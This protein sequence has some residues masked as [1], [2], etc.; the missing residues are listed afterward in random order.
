V[1]PAPES[2]QALSLVTQSLHLW[3]WCAYSGHLLLGAPT[4]SQTFSGGGLFRPDI[5]GPSAIEGPALFRTYIHVGYEL[6]AAFFFG[7]T[8]IHRRR[9]ASREKGA[10]VDS[11][12][13]ASRQTMMSCHRS[14]QTTAQTAPGLH[15]APVQLRRR[16][17]IRRRAPG[18]RSPSE[19]NGPTVAPKRSASVFF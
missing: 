12:T 14:Q 2:P 17:G 9:C 8:W 4:S 18:R 5:P 11:F 13:N 16:H 6:R 10:H 1:Y 3:C 7:R 19:L 15:L